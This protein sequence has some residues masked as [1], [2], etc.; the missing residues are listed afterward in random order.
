MSIQ[1]QV[2]GEI[3]KG[4][5][6]M[7]LPFSKLMEVTKKLYDTDPPVFWLGFH[8]VSRTIGALEAMKAIEEKALG[9]GDTEMAKNLAELTGWE[10]FP[11]ARSRAGGELE[12]LR[13]YVV[14]RPIVTDYVNLELDL[15]LEDAYVREIQ[16]A[17]IYHEGKPVQKGVVVS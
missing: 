15:N 13:D 17:W 7:R 11:C 12:L 8:E 3:R 2:F 6:G 9:F 4:T 16:K 14:T 1:Q 5:E 10:A